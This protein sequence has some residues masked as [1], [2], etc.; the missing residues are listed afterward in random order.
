MPERSPMS[1]PSCAGTD[2]ERFHTPPSWSSHRAV[3]KPTVVTSAGCR[4][5]RACVA[6][7]PNRSMIVAHRRGGATRASSSRCLSASTT[8][9][10]VA[11]SMTSCVVRSRCKNSRALAGSRSRSASSNPRTGVPTRQPSARIS[12]P[13]GSLHAAAIDSAASAGMSPAAAC[14]VATAASTAHMAPTRDDNAKIASI[15][16]VENPGYGVMVHTSKKTVSS[17]PW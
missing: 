8:S 6:M 17:S 10:I 3:L 1:P 2:G 13:T 4:N 5:E 11:V 15:R 14:A 7:S 16:S 12:T 9:T